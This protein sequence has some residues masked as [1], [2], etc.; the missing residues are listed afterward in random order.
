[1]PAIPPPT[2]ATSE[3]MSAVRVCDWRPVGSWVIQGE[4]LESIG[5]D[6][7]IRGGLVWECEGGNII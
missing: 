5:L 7:F 6:Y 3:D 1:M 4:R 2:I